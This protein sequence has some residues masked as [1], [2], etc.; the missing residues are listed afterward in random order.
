MKILLALITLAISCC[1]RPAE[2][3]VIDYSVGSQSR[4]AHE[5][6]QGGVPVSAWSIESGVW[7]PV[8]LFRRVDPPNDFGLGVC[9]TPSGSCGTG[10]QNEI[11]SNGAYRDVIAFSTAGVIFDAI[12]LS[13]LD[14]TFPGDDAW[15]IYLTNLL[16]PDLAALTPFAAGAN[17]HG[18]FHRVP[19]G[20]AADW[21][22]VT[23]NGAGS[24][25]LVRSI[26]TAAPSEV[27]EPGTMALLMLPALVIARRLRRAQW[28]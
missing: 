10:Q 15:S 20:Q 17:G 27:P 4:L 14:G 11:D 16:L 7:Q 25:F 19:I 21:I 18:I 9:N 24:D 23:T 3:T 12:N 1:D 26:E 5:I 6:T 8:E 13:S 28:S 2:A 22:Y